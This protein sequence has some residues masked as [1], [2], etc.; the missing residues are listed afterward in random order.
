[1]FEVEPCPALPEML[2][3]ARD[4][5]FAD[6][7]RESDRDGSEAPI[8]YERL[9]LGH[10]LTWC[11]VRPGFEFSSLRPRNHQFD[12]RSANVDDEDSFFHRVS[13]FV[14]PIAAPSCITAIGTNRSARAFFV[15]PLSFFIRSRDT[16]RNCHC[17]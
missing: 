17:A 8:L 3:F 10:Q 14:G 4:A 11:Q 7:R 6:R 16:S 5:A 9:D 13:D 1:L 2:R 12:V 15:E